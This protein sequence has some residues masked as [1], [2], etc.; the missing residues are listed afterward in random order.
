MTIKGSITIANG[1]A[2][3]SPSTFARPM[4]MSRIKTVAEIGQGLIDT[5]ITLNLK[6]RPN[7]PP[8]EISYAGAP[9]R[10]DPQR[11]AVP[12]SPHSSAWPSWSKASRNSNACRRSS[13][14]WRVEE[15][16]MRK[17][18]EAKLQAYYAQRDEIRLRQRELKV[19]AEMRCRRPRSSACE[20]GASARRQCRNQQ[21]GNE[22]QQPRTARAPAHGQAGARDRRAADRQNSR[23]KPPEAEVL[24]T[25]PPSQ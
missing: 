1:V 5:A 2:G 21:A 23:S 15:E 17:E 20:L 9:E 24:I 7:L 19:H 13:S 12:N 22:A 10:A 16:R 4:P 25:E 3:F 18:D 11:G 6:A 8:M 14:G